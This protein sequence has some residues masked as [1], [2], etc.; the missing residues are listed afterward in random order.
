M[1][2]SRKWFASR[3]HKEALRL[4]RLLRSSAAEIEFVASVSR[5]CLRAL[6][7]CRGY[8]YDEKYVGATSEA[9]WSADRVD[10]LKRDGCII[11]HT[12]VKV[13]AGPQAFARAKDKLQNWRHLQL[14]WASVDPSTPIKVGGKFGI[15]VHEMVAWLV[16]PN[17]HIDNCSR[18]VLRVS[19]RIL[20]LRTFHSA[21][22]Q[23]CRRAQTAWPQDRL[24]A[25]EDLPVLVP[26]LTQL[27]LHVEVAVTQPSDDLPG[28]MEKAARVC[29]EKRG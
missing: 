21:E 25:S 5:H 24:T 1:I 9:P 13:G 16:N 2:L 23:H 12:R 8:N 28:C 10:Q 11:N 15:V 6:P 4:K 26:A 14:G 3:K 18:K 17:S 20:E 22:L 19:R 7:S 27:M 29:I